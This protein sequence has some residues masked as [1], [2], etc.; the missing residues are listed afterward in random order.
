[1]PD[2]GLPS[3]V[4]FTVPLATVL[5]QAKRPG[6]VPGYGSVDPA[7]ASK[8]ADAAANS[9]RSGFCVTFTTPEGHAAAHGCARLIK[10]R[11]ARQGNKRARHGGKR[12][13]PPG[14][15]RDGPAASGWDF[16]PDN[17]RDGP[18]GGCGAWIL[19]LPDGSRYRV[20]MH[21]IP[22]DDC[23]HRYE[24][25][26]YRPGALLRHLVEIRDGECTFTGCSHPARLSDFEHAIPHHTGGRTCGC[27]AG[28]RSRRCHRVKQSPGW[29]VTQDKPAWHRW[30]TPSGRSYVKGPKKYFD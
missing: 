1:M 7:L 27:N 5:G 24:T 12:P 20:A 8:L 13:G 22:L 28:P 29:N 25:T 21:A 11:Q 10:D 6:E 17:T 2:P 26:A 18:D 14:S 16:T 30:T 23:D 3:L 9:P 19:T 15:T 4:N